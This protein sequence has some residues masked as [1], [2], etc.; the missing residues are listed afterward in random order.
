MTRWIGLLRGINVG[1]H[2]KLPMAGLRDICLALWPQ[3]NPRTL[4]ASGNVIFEA[5][6][7]ATTLAVDLGAAI[8]EVYGLDVPI[9]VIEEHVF[10][11]SVAGCPFHAEEGKGVHGFFCFT[12]PSVDAAKR[13]ALMVDGE[14][15][16]QDGTTIWLHTP[17]GISGSKLGEK[18]GQVIGHVP[19]TARNLNTLRKLVEMLDA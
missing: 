7:G 8:K 14:G 4:I 5:D 12:Q 6:E 10:R 11:A 17:Q 15:L 1:G 18:L 9:L 3:S 16:A 19:T 2:N 13:N